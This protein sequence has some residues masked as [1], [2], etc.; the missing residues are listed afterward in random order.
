MENKITPEM[1]EQA[2]KA[3]SVEELLKLAKENGVA[4]T[5]QQAQELFN[6]WHTTCELSD[7]ELDSVSGGCGGGS[8]AT[9]CPRCQ[10]TDVHLENRTSDGKGTFGDV[11][12][13]IYHY[14]CNA[15]GHQFEERVEDV[16]QQ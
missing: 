9:T 14:R 3:G 5:A 11:W 16:I 12:V 2:K 4:M 15:C 6:Q 10:S 1:I 8:S 7:D 13:D